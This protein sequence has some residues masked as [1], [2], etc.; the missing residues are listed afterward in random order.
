MPFAFWYIQLP[1]R[2]VR[3]RCRL[4]EDQVLS[5]W[6]SYAHGSGQGADSQLCLQGASFLLLHA[7]RLRLLIN[8]PP[9]AFC[10]AVDHGASSFGCAG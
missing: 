7:M 10:H 9:D 1:G 4:E 2:D 6:P 3:A 5:V 8:N